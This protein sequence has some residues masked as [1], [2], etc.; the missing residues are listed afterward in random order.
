MHGIFVHPDKTYET[1]FTPVWQYKIVND[2]DGTHIIEINPSFN[3]EEVCGY[4][5]TNPWQVEVH[6]LMPD[7]TRTD[8]LDR[9][10]MQ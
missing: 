3:A 8:I 9:W 2:G 1:D 4:H 5:S 6:N 7:E 10:M